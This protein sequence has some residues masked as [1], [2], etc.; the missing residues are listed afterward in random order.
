[1][2]TQH[3]ILEADGAEMLLICYWYWHPSVPPA[4]VP[5]VQIAGGTL[6]T[7]DANSTRHVHTHCLVPRECRHDRLSHIPR[8]P[9]ELTTHISNIIIYYHHQV[10]SSDAIK[11]LRFKDKDKNLWSEDKDKDLKSGDNDKDN[12]L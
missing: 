3:T 12:D 9:E 1:M 7:G 10:L 11:N 4:E 2:E 6:D 5:V 8:T